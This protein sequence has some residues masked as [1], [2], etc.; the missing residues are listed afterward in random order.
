MAFETQYII[1]NIS[2][3]NY[4]YCL[5]ECFLRVEFRTSKIEYKMDHF[6]KTDHGYGSSTIFVK[7]SISD[8]PLS[9]NTTLQ[10]ASHY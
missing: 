9:F 2:I 7:N 8:V 3:V 10:R 1:C 5:S 6:A 4:M